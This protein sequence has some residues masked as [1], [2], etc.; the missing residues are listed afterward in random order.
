MT[1]AVK[2]SRL[3]MTICKI[4]ILCASSFLFH[5][6]I[7]AK[8]LHEVEKGYF[9]ISNVVV[10]DNRD[11]FILLNEDYFTEEYLRGLLKELSE[12]FPEPDRI[13]IHLYSSIEQVHYFV[14]G[15]PH[16]G[17]QLYVES[18]DPDF[19]NRHAHGLLFRGNGDEVIRYYIP[20]DND[21]DLKSIVV[22][23]KDPAYSST[24]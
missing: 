8:P 5:N 11:I 9:V 6:E 7:S 23:G 4:S 10:K 16:H 3:K 15:H 19:W 22:K 2:C 13:D 1:I 20:G 18:K 12:E 14:D 21:F 17:S 24:K